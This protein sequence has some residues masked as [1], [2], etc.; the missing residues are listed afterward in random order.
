MKSQ[1][2]FN[3]SAAHS[4]FC[5]IYTIS[6][7]CF[8]CSVWRVCVNSVTS[9]VFFLAFARGWVIRSS[10]SHGAFER[11]TLVCVG[12][13]VCVWGVCFQGRE[14]ELPVLF[15]LKLVSSLTPYALYGSLCLMSL[16]SIKSRLIGKK[17]HNHT[18]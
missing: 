2:F 7:I 14:R 16:I 9:A 4:V 13:G 18:L 10:I 3:V 8:M 12:V 1:G 17:T 5:C 6:L 11:D 15:A